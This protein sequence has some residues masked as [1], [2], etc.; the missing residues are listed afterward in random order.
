MRQ[1]LL[2]TVVLLGGCAGGE[3]P[4]QPADD[5]PGPPV[6]PE[7]ASEL[8]GLRASAASVRSETWPYPEVSYV[9][10]WVA[11]VMG[12]VDAAGNVRVW[13]VWLLEPLEPAVVRFWDRTG[14]LMGETGEQ[15]RLPDEFLRRSAPKF[16]VRLRVKAPA[17]AAFLSVALGRSGLETERV[18]WP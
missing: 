10:E 4:H 1:A 11:P 5:Q 7:S 18:V 16:E 12:E 17:G 15:V 2:L 14:A 6:V 9:L 8:G 3:R 13:N